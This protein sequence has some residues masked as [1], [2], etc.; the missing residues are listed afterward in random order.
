M[1][2]YKYN[3]L[4]S[5]QNLSRIYQVPKAVHELDFLETL[6]CVK[7]SLFLSNNYAGR[8]I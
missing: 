2:D 3:L 7:T 5:C 1:S 8:Q 6:S 4:S